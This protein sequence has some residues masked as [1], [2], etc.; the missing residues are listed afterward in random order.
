MTHNEAIKA[1]CKERGIRQYELADM[2]GITTQAITNF[3]HSNNVRLDT[4]QKIIECADYELI[5]R[6]KNWIRL[7]EGELRVDERKGQE[8]CVRV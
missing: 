1:M 8:K 6:P 4:F 7:M 3:V 2:L 5:I